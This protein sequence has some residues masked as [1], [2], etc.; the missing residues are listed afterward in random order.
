MKRDV[1]SL[2]GLPDLLALGN[3]AR[4]PGCASDLNRTDVCRDD[5]VFLRNRLH[6]PS[7]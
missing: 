1:R 2:Q 5:I 3:V 4:G 6:H 7:T